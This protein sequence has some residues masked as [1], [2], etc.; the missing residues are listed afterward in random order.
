MALPIKPETFVTYDPIEKPLLN[1]SPEYAQ[2]IGAGSI[3][4]GGGTITIQV[5]TCPFLEPVDVY[6]AILASFLPDE[7]YMLTSEGTLAPNS[8]VGLVPWKSS[9]TAGIQESPFGDIRMSDLPA[10][11][12]Y[13]FLA[14]APEGSIDNFYLWSSFFEIP[15]GPATPNI[16]PYIDLVVDDT[17]I[18]FG[19]LDNKRRN[20]G[21]G[22]N[23][24]VLPVYQ[25]P[26]YSTS[27]VNLQN[28][29]TYN[30]GVTYLKTLPLLPTTDVNH[31]DPD[32]YPDGMTRS[33]IFVSGRPA[34]C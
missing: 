34:D 8:L 17:V 22:T 23:L 19:R 6:F 15:I 13:L 11:T 27:N 7:L 16:K 28:L 25:V 33:S 9:I 32:Q 24:G 21:V 26:P 10:G 29:C 4:W 30:G 3:A 5:E 20:L 14:V 18:D 1:S 2:P 31:I 12:Y